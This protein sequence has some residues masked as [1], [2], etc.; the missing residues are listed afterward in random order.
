MG[1]FE[2]SAKV[3]STFVTYNPNMYRSKQLEV[4]L[5]VGVADGYEGWEY[6]QNDYLPI[7]G[8][9][10]QWMYLKAILNPELMALGIELPLN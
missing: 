5:V 8:V 3:Q 1:T 6:A 7:M 9:S 4:N 10:A 2:N